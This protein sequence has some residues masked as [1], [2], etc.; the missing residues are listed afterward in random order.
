[1]PEP[2]TDQWRRSPK[3]E[4]GLDK[5]DPYPT[6][7]YPFVTEDESYQFRMPDAAYNDGSMPH[8][9]PDGLQSDGTWPRHFGEQ[10][11][12]NEDNTTEI[13]HNTKKRG[14]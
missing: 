3:L 7:A 12:R 13:R 11:V 6:R 8:D 10:P 9:L 14:Y 5:P 1:V 2:N 4:T